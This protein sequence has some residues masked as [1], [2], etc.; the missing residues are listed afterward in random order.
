MATIAAGSSVTGFVPNA[1][2]ITFTP[3]A[4]GRISFNGRNQDGSA[5]TPRE[6]YSETA[7]A[8]ASGATFSA[9]AIGNDGTYTDIQSSVS[10]GEVGTVTAAQIISGALGSYT[11]DTTYVTADTSGGVE[12]GTLVRWDTSMSAWVFDFYRSAKVL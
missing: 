2:T 9:E 7:I 11:A 10:G 1:Q 6:I 8:L 5:I 4:G 12:K 3:G